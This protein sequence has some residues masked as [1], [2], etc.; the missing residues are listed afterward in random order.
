MRV[1]TL[2]DGRA[3]FHAFHLSVWI[4]QREELIR[5]LPHNF[6]IFNFL[7]LSL[8]S[9]LEFSIVETRFLFDF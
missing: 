6:E 2:E 9:V 1:P 3:Q 8:Q 4:N 5:S 7:P